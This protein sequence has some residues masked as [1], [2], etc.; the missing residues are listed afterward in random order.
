M[1]LPQSEACLVGRVLP[2]YLTCDRASGV[3]LRQ[4]ELRTTR[5]LSHSL[6]RH[7][8]VRRRIMREITHHDDVVVAHALHQN[9]TAS[10][11]LRKPWRL[12]P[13]VRI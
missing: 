12:W 1:H 7:L 8:P 6:E 5:L 3:L 9:G 4:D 2:A 11:R 13:V 10:E